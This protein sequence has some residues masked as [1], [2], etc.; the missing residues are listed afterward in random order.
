MDRSSLFSRKALIGGFA[1]LAV[2][3]ATALPAAAAAPNI[4]AWSLERF[5]KVDAKGRRTPQYGPNP[6]GYLIYTASGKM[7]AVLTGSQRPVLTPAGSARDRSDCTASLVDFLAYAGTYRI[8]GNRVFHHVETSVFTNLIGTTLERE[9]SIHGDTLSI[10][11][12]PPYIWGY[13]S[14]LVWRRA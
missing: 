10:R 6:V 7:S 1:G 3:G 13:Q 2:A 9:F 4:G 11:T 8:S 12:I 5:D 14:E